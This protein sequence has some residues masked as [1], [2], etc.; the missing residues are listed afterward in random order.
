MIP[1]LHLFFR[2]RLRRYKTIDEETGRRILDEWENHPE[3]GR[4]RL[5]VLLRAEGLK[6][7]SFELKHFLRDNGIGNPPST[8]QV[9]QLSWRVPRIPWLAYPRRWWRP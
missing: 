3:L 5:G 8:R 4:K 1:L 7:D 9:P 2:P 6:L